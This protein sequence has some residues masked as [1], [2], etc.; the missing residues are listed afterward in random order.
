MTAED[1]EPAPAGAENAPAPEGEESAQADAASLEEAPAGET[2][3][4]DVEASNGALERALRER[5]E[6]LDLAQR[7]RA[8]LDNF[9][10]RVAR[11]SQAAEVR[12]RTEVARNLI[13]AIDN[14][15]RALRAAGVDPDGGPVEG[16]PASREVSAH[17][18]LAEGVALVYRELAGGLERSG[19]G[20]FDPT[21]ERFDPALHE[22]VSTRPA[23][24]GEQAGV[25]AE[26]LERGYRVGEQV[27]R[28]ARVVVAG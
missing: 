15:E 14:L 17:L 23:A 8:E 9:R 22:A 13:G 26:T 5:D 27:L 12:G 7:A 2:A 18:A 24:E 11:D 10:K 3:G 25:V 4:D 20:A 6:Y 28:P 21:G 16:E 19:V 1:N